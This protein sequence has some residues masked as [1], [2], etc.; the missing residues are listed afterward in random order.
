VTVG[1][2]DQN[3]GNAAVTGAF[4]DSIVVDQVSSGGSLTQVAS[5]T[6][7][8]PRP[9][10][11]APIPPWQPSTPRREEPPRRPPPIAR[12]VWRPRIAGGVQTDRLVRE[13]QNF[14]VKLTVAAHE[15]FGAWREG[16][17]DDLVLAVALACWLAE[18]EP[19]GSA[20]GSGAGGR[21]RI[22]E[23]TPLE[24]RP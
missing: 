5:G 22:D 2:N 6:S 3:V 16:D 17:H 4:T 7:S 9:W 19:H 12:V 18:R 1:W 24:Y 8:R 14:R 13:L 15:T 10:P 21:R 23:A 11:L 20:A